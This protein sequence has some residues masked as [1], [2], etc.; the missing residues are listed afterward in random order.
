VCR[1]KERK[2]E[3]EKDAISRVTEKKKKGEN[4][5]RKKEERKDSGVV[6]GEKSFREKKRGRNEEN[7]RSQP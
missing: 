1:E 6:Q 4:Y 5:T 7:K 2:K 3:D